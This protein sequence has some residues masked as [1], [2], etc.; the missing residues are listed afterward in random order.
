MIHESSYEW[1]ECRHCGHYSSTL[2][3]SWALEGWQE[4]EECGE[5]FCSEKCLESHIPYCGTPSQ[6]ELERAGQKRLSI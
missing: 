3:S 4:C 5:A 2:E 1:G 6:E